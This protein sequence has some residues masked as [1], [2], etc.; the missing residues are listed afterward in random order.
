M[1]FYLLPKTLGNGEAVIE[2]EIETS[3]RIPI[4][5]PLQEEVKERCLRGQQQMMAFSVGTEF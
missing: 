4:K 2:I 3:R 1:L 5:H